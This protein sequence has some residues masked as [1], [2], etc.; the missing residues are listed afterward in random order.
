MQISDKVPSE[1]IAKVASR[2]TE[3][4]VYK[5]VGSLDPHNCVYEV[6]DEILNRALGRFR[7]RMKDGI[8]RAEVMASAMEFAGQISKSRNEFI[9]S[10]GRQ[11]AQEIRRDGTVAKTYAMGP[12]DGP[13]ADGSSVKADDPDA[14]ENWREEDAQ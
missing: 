1:P 8:S 12:F 7:R 11:L 6:S 9:S 5:I 4:M 3:A 10:L 13:P 2:E 14:G